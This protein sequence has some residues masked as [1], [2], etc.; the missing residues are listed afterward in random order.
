MWWFISN[1]HARVRLG[2]NFNIAFVQLKN[3]L[4]TFI[5]DIYKKRLDIFIFSSFVVC[6]LYLQGV[7]NKEWREVRIWIK[8]IVLEDMV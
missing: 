5:S 3:K 4:D 1:F 7:G 2:T 8:K 6:V